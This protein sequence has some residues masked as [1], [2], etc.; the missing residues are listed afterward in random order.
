[1]TK[2]DRRVIAYAAFGVAAISLLWIILAAVTPTTNYHLAPLVA[3]LAAPTTARM[4]TTTRLRAPLSVA[5]VAV[6]VA[7]TTVAAVLIQ[8]AGWAQGPSF[9]PSITPLTELVVLIAVGG[10]LGAVI[11]SVPFGDK[12]AT[13]DPAASTSSRSSSTD[14]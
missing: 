6:G 7:V 13:Q 4:T 1:M 2:T 11:A 10:V 8:V 3:V 9:S 5:T 14:H 12:P